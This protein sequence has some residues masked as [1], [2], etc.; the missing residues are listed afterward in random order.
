MNNAYV[1]KKQLIN[2]YTK[3]KSMN[4]VAKYLK[5]SIHKVV[6]WMK[7]YGI[8]RRSHSEA[9]YL[10]ANPNGDPFKI[11]SLLTPNEK[12]L[13]GIAIGIYLGEGNKVVKHSLRIA[14]SDPL[15]IKLFLQFL[16]DICRFQSN[17][18]SYSIVCFND[19]KSNEA[20]LYWANQLKISP[21]KFGKITQ[22]P[23]R[24]EGTY[25]KKS[26][27]GVCTVQANNMKLTSWMRHQVD[28][29]R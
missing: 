21:Q 24:G 15:I 25:K 14:N 10:K 29:L 7:K 26:Q 12:F 1:S 6:Y 18:I 22:I 8:K 2:L 9:T 16:F 28:V 23:T 17:R 13:M 11:K 4:D 27:F 3:G 20:R 19:A 5:C